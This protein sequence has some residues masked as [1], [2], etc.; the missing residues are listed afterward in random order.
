MFKSFSLKTEEVNDT[1]Y[2]CDAEGKILG[3]LASD[4]AYVLRGKHS[5]QFTPHVNMR[6]HVVVTNSQKICVTRN[7]LQD[8]IY[9]RHTGYPGGLR[10]T[11][12]E[13]ML[14]KSPNKVLRLAVKRMLPKNKLGDALLRNLKIY[15]GSEHP[16][17]AQQTTPFPLD[18]N[19][20][21]TVQQGE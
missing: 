14:E 19:G 4:I 13:D 17:A 1:W 20:K 15:E 18:E 9:Y 2:H 7:K 6:Y 8:K 21:K 5:V 10:E 12:L 11:T 16:H 3:R